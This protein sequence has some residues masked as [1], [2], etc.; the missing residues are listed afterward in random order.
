LLRSRVAFFHVI[1]Q[2]PIRAFSILFRSR[3]SIK[4]INWEVIIPW[5]MG[6]E[7]RYRGCRAERDY[8]LRP[9]PGNRTGSGRSG[10]TSLTE[11]ALPSASIEMLKGLP[12]T[13]VSDE[14]GPK[15]RAERAGD[16]PGTPLCD[17]SQPVDGHRRHQ[18]SSAACRRTRSGF[19]RGH[20]AC[21]P[22]ESISAGA[23]ARRGRA[24]ARGSWG[25]WSPAEIQW[26]KR[27]LHCN[28]A[29]RPL[30]RWR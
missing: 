20:H 28:C 7:W 17:L 6:S 9:L 21:I 8:E 23:I 3:S 29:R 22:V 13:S 1:D 5:N 26:R 30:K 25:P 15:V 18:R 12:V 2:L 19:D 4:T 24:K 10:F 27:A 16:H 14:E 11:P